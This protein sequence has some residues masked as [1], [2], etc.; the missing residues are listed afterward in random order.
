MGSVELAPFVGN[1]LSYSLFWLNI[2]VNVDARFK[3]AE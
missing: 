2:P 1:R 3:F